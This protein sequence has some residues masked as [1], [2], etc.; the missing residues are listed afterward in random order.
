MDWFF[1]LGE[2]F[3]RLGPEEKFL[4]IRLVYN[5]SFEAGAPL[6]TA[7]KDRA[8]ALGT[9]LR[10]LQSLEGILKD[11]NMLPKKITLLDKVKNKGR[12]QFIEGVEK[13]ISRDKKISESGGVN[14]ENM[15]IVEPLLVDDKLAREN[16][17]ERAAVRLWLMVLVAHSN[18]NG[19]V[20][21]VSIAD[22]NRLLGK[23][24]KDRHRSQLS[25]LTRLR[26]I[27]GYKSGFT[28][29][30]LFGKMKGEYVLNGKHPLLSGGIYSKYDLAIVSERANEKLLA[31]RMVRYA[32]AP[33]HPSEAL[34]LLKE[35]GEH[36]ATSDKNGNADRM[37][38]KAFF[39]L[40]ESLKGEE[41]S[42]HLQQYLMNTSLAMLR[43]MGDY[44]ISLETAVRYIDYRELFSKAFIKEV[45]SDVLGIDNLDN[46]AAQSQTKA[47]FEKH[48]SYSS[49]SEGASGSNATIEVIRSVGLVVGCALCVTAKSWRKG[50]FLK[51][52]S[53]IDKVETRV[54]RV[55]C[56]RERL[57][58]FRS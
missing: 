32:T 25:L 20:S 13:L 1:L 48:L 47:F 49:W 38:G 5:Q 27:I 15:T 35:L 14:P 17:L 18:E 53:V 41:L 22:F 46:D 42:C 9:S 4:L 54:S 37:L 57:F 26:I 11:K 19:V 21:G 52:D 3:K 28:G 36:I 7:P 33:Q 40:R 39:A 30:V 24:A 23:F 16:G 43:A 45:A 58:L 50:E 8:K 29:K 51:L 12:Y 10:T 2:V 44:Q 55:V 56:C 34:P 31:F 6:P